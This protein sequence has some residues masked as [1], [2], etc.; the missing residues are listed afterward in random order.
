M[1]EDDGKYVHW[2]LRICSFNRNIRHQIM[3]LAMRFAGVRGKVERKRAPKAAEPGIVQVEVIA[4]HS[5]LDDVRHAAQFVQQIVDSY[6]G[7]C[8]PIDCGNSNEE[9]LLHARV[10]LHTAYL[11]HLCMDVNKD[12][13]LFK[14]VRW[15]E[16]NT[17]GG[18]SEVSRVGD[19]ACEPQPMSPTGDGTGM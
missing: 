4:F 13:S 3:L 8:T 2:T 16:D 18:A 19:S 12:G 7:Q 10:T 11:D 6:R 17:S 9:R 14:C 15:T 5:A 1:P